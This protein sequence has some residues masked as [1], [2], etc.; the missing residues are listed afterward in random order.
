MRKNLLLLPMLVGLISQ[1]SEN[2]SEKEEVNVDL[3]LGEEPSILDKEP[4]LDVE[5]M[6]S[7]IKVNRH[8]RRKQKALAR[9]ENKCRK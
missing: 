4:I 5:Q 6:Y 7:D 1:L 2:S 3:L 9:K 8:E